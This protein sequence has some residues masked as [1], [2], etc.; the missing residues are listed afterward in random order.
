MFKKI[1]WALLEV[2]TIG[3]GTYIFVSTMVDE[4]EIDKHEAGMGAFLIVL[5]FLLRNWRMTLFVKSEDNNNKTTQKI[6]VQSKSVNA[7]L[8]LIISLS[9]FMLNRKITNTASTVDSNETEIEN[10]NSRID[11]LDDIDLSNI[12]NRLDDMEY[13]ESRIEDLENY[14][15]SHY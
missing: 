14:S 8:I 11:G 6:E 7:I 1:I 10:L 4:Y 5:G 12:E 13:L 9:L 3:S 15:H 2:A